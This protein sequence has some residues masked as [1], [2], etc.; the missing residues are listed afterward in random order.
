MV[1]MWMTEMQTTLEMQYRQEIEAFRSKLVH[2][3]IEQVNI[4]FK[5]VEMR[6]NKYQQHLHQ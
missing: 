1:I 4:L 2:E 6:A 3:Y 5:S